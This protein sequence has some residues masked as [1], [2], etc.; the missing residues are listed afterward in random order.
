MAL[1]GPGIAWAQS[2]DT[3]T[4]LHSITFQILADLP[5][6]PVSCTGWYAAPRGQAGSLY[7]SV[8]VTAGH[9]EV[10]HIV[11]NPKGL[12]RMVVLAHIDRLGA[13]A[14]VGARMD[15]RATRTF[16]TLASAPPRPGARALV[17]G[18]SAG[19]LT[20]A[21]LTTIADCH[22][23]YIC[24]HSDHALRPGMSGAPILSLDTGQLIG[25]L[26]GFPLVHNRVDPHAI[27]ATSSIALRTLIELAVPGNLDVD[28]AG[29]IL[30]PMLPVTPGRLQN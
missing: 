4:A 6:L 26:I 16:L 12:E 15:R 11:R 29:K 8:Y 10:P 20:Q 17:A 13:D 23:G 2:V 7:V 14:A 21:V 27:W 22:H 1:T 18:Y 28:R 24:F 5:G 19:H 25:I 30:S 3:W 9:C